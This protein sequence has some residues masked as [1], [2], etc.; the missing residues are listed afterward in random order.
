MIDADLIQGVKFHTPEAFFKG[1]EEAKFELPE[2][3][4]S[5]ISPETA[6]L[7]PKSSQLSVSGQ[8]MI[9]MV[10]FPG[11]GKSQFS[12]THLADYARVNRDTLGSWQKCVAK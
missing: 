1:M 11:S 5:K 10:G 6:L 2:F 8:E 7:E 4:P 12:T 3:D 9:V